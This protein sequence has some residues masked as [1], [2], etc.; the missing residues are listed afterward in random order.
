MRHGEDSEA[1]MS[2]FGEDLL[3]INVG[4]AEKL[5]EEYESESY[6][7]SVSRDHGDRMSSIFRQVVDIGG[8]QDFVNRF[9]LLFLQ[10][11]A[12]EI[13]YPATRLHSTQDYGM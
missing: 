6:T 13:R 9:R 10:A 5:K 3:Y 1:I 8:T 12:Q 2:S 7:V 4:F 11:R